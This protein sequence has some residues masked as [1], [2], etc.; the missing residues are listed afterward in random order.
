MVYYCDDD[1]VTLKPDL[2][3]ESWHNS[4]LVFLRKSHAQVQALGGH[5]ENGRHRPEVEDCGD[6]HPAADLRPEAANSAAAAVDSMEVADGV[7]AAEA[8]STDALRIGGESDDSEDD[9]ESLDDSDEDDMNRNADQYI[10]QAAECRVTSTRHDDWL[11]RGPFLA[12]LPWKIYMMRVRRRRK[13]VQANAD[14]TELFFFDKHYALSTLYCQEIRYAASC[15][16]PRLVGSVCPPKEEDGGEPHAAYKLMLFSRARCSGASHCADPLIFRSL[17]LPSDKPDDEKAIIRKPRFDLCWKA[18][19]CEMK[20]KAEIA[21]AKEDL[22]EKIAVLADTTLMKDAKDGAAKEMFRLRPHLLKILAVHF[23]K[24]VEQMPQGIV[25]IA[26][27][28][29]RCLYGKSLYNLHEQ[30]HLSEFAAKE[31]KKINDEMDM[32][33]LVR[34]K[35]FREED[36]GGFENDVDSEDEA[37][38]KRSFIHSEFVGGAGEDD[39][40]EIDETEGDLTVRRQALFQMSLDD[41]KALLRREKEL[42]RASAP[43]RHKEAD[44]QMKDYAR[45]FSGV[46]HLPLP[47]VPS[48][49]RSHLAVSMLH[50]IAANFQRVVAKEM[51]TQQP[52]SESITGSSAEF[53]IE[54][55]QNLFFR[56]DEKEQAVCVTVPLDDALLGPGHVAWKLIQDI[57]NDSTMISNSMKSRFLSSRCRFGLWSKLGVFMSRVIKVRVRWY[58]PCANCQIIWAC[59]VLR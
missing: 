14:H 34:K 56:N 51:R 27:L 36:Q 20:I 39:V 1:T 8:N 45:A 31:M 25:E 43:G 28:I 5:P 54:D 12:D 46:F 52:G 55:I 15:A 30:L 16:I 13:P 41:C 26:D 58:T 38:K 7:P 37:I 17:V 23:D 57:K 6:T 35:P 49:R 40:D 21:A 53:N 11:H 22:A 29:S 3:S 2:S 9:K 59:R 24:H 50:H 48:Q 42:E 44:V 10:L 47:E 33:L 19:R 4:Y 32:D 18:C